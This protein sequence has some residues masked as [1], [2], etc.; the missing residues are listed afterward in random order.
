MRRRAAVWKIWWVLFVTLTVVSCAPFYFNA[1]IPPPEPVSVSDPGGFPYRE[2]W[3]GFVFN[4]EKVGFTHLV[5]EQ[6]DGS[7]GF[8]ITTEAR[9]KILFLGISKNVILRSEDVV[10]P[11]LVL[12]SFRYDQVIDDA[13]SHIEG[14]VTDGLFQASQI[15]N[16][17]PRSIEKRLD[18]PLYPVSVINLYPVLKGLSIG[19]R[20][21]YLVFDPQ[22]QAFLD[23]SQTVEAFEESRELVVEPSFRIATTMLNH[24]VSTWINTRGEAVFELALGGVLITYKEDEERA[25]Q[26]LLDAALNKKDLILDF[27][28]VRVDAVLPCPRDGTVLE[29]ALAGVAEQL[30]PLMGPGQEVTVDGEAPPVKAVYRITS[31]GESPVRMKTAPLTEGERLLYLASTIHMESGKREI[32]DAA[33]MIVAGLS[34]QIERVER[35]TEWVSREIRDEAVDSSSALDVFRSRRG[36][37]QA[38]TLLYAAMARSA[39]IPTKLV[40]G[41]VY[42]EDLGFLYHSW[43]ESYLNGWI[44]VDPTFNQVGIDATHIKLVEGPFWTSTLSLGKVI[45]KITASVLRYETECKKGSNR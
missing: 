29:I 43:A 36:E 2:L 9:L 40:G 4:G 44:T 10:G 34:S 33:D 13:V 5:I 19:S 20:Y 3:H 15:T 16:G 32:K 12:R 28:L 23:V 37:C 42:V 30:P 26:Y 27:S 31:G 21:T 1:R 22:T 35:L 18:D 41:L 24:E 11:D 38:H 14:S 17:R 45:G 39:G 8:L 25:R 7:D 6:I